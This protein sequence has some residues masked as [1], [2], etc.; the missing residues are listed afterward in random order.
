MA[1]EK[2]YKG[3]KVRISLGGKTLYHATSCKV[4][5][6]TELEEIATK[7]TDGKISVPDGYSWS[8]STEA[9]VADKPAN[10][11]QADAMDLIDYQ[12]AGTELDFEFTTSVTGDFVLKGKVLVS[13]ASVDASTG[14]AVK[15]SFSFV[16]Q[17]DLTREVVV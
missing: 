3:K 14:S 1:S 6:S 2:F 13:Q 17:G 8:A 16:G 10:S 15:G 4:D 5:I 11:T 12:L 9:L 7:D